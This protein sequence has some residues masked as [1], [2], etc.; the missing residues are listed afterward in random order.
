MDSALKAR[1][2]RK[3]VP[4]RLYYFDLVQM[5]G[6]LT[7]TLHET[8]SPTTETTRAPVDSVYEAI[9]AD[10][11]Y[12]KQTSPFRKNW[13]GDQGERVQHLLAK[14]TSPHPR[15]PTRRRRGSD[16]RRRETSRNAADYASA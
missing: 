14:S 1:R 11:K 9:I 13:T 16:T 2:G 3:P 4:A 6:P 15:C 10:L 8:T 7:L 5:Y 12:A